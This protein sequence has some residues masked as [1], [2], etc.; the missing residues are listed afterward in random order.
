MEVIDGTI[1]LLGKKKAD[2]EAQLIEREFPD[3]NGMDYLIGMPI[4]SNE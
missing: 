4:G 1:V 3:L 2:L